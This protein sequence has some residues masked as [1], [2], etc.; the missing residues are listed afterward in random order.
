M[1]EAVGICRS[2]QSGWLLMHQRIGKWKLVA[3]PYSP[4]S[5]VV[6]DALR[7]LGE[8]DFGFTDRRLDRPFL[9]QPWPESPPELAKIGNGVVHVVAP[10][11]DGADPVW[12][13]VVCGFAGEVSRGK[14]RCR[15]SQV[16]SEIAA[17]FKDSAQ[18]GGMASFAKDDTPF[19]RWLVVRRN[20]RLADL[21]PELFERAAA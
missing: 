9:L 1:T 17:W 15:S 5:A 8:R 20:W 16:P 3:Q 6:E 4:L 11:R 19:G 13:C 18:S 21:Y 7:D 14:T 12:G 2:I 10:E